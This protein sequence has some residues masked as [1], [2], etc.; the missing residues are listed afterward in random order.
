MKTNNA[1]YALNT[2]GIDIKS[3]EGST[4]ISIGEILYSSKGTKFYISEGV[5]N[6]NHNYNH[7]YQS[8]THISIYPN[9]SN[10]K[11]YIHI[12]PNYFDHYKYQVLSYDG[13]SIQ[14]GY[15]ENNQHISLINLS[16]GFYLLKISYSSLEE[17]TLPIIKIN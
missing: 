10:D 7:V 4:N 9:P 11:I 17:K 14:N 5:Q 15:I 13:K 12:S 8:L 3:S 6:A 2:S 1:Q 16:A